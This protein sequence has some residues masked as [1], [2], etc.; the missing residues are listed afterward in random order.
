MASVPYWRLASFYGFYFAVLGAFS[1]YF[2]LYLDDRGISPWWISV[3]LSFWYTTRVFV[4]SLWAAG[5]ERARHPVSWLRLGSLL[6]GLFLMLFLLP[7]GLWGMA[8]AI[9]GFSILMNGILPQFEALT[10]SHI[11]EAPSQ[12]GR[13]RVWGSIGFLVVVVGYGLVFQKLNWFWLVPLMLPLLVLTW[14]AALR[15]DFAADYHAKE[16]PSWHAVRDILKRKQVRAFFISALLMQWSFGP[17]YVF[18]SLHLEQNGYQPVV[19]GSYWAL[20]VLAEIIVLYYSRYWLKYISATRVV[21]L[22]LLL[23][24]LRWWLTAQ[25][26]ENVGLMAMVQI[27]HAINFGAFFAACMVLVQRF[28]P[29]RLSVHGQ[30]ILYGFSSGIGGV[31]GALLAGVIWEYYG[32]KAAFMMGAIVSL[33]GLLL[34]IGF[35]KPRRKTQ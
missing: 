32:G 34:S 24:S 26:P 8:V 35:I 19:I 12:Y 16:K 11:Q 9:L 23:G 20:G 33:I 30:G 4:P 5:S 27:I 6:A 18:Y 7:I 28:F 14:I 29:G 10:L 31:A 13:I 3:L 2:S 25:Y 22:A 21:Q 15:N 17:F 1:P